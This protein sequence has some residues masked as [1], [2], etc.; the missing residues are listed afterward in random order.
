[1]D[2]EPLICSGGCDWSGV[3]RSKAFPEEDLASRVHKGVSFTHYNM[4]M[5]CFGPIYTTPLALR[6]TCLS[7]PIQI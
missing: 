7:A 3:V 2:N 4:M 6:V 5:S 1:M